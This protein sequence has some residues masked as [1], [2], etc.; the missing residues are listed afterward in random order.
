MG[1]GLSSRSQN[2]KGR[3]A[4]CCL[5]AQSCPTLCD[6]MDCS[7]LGS[8]VHGISQAR[9]L[10]WVAICFSRGSS[11]PRDRTW[12]S[13]ITG[14]FFFF[15]FFNH[16]ATREARRKAWWTFIKK[17]NQII[18]WTC[19]LNRRV[20]KTHR[21]PLIH[22]IF[23]IILETSTR[24]IIKGN[25]STQERWYVFL[26][27]NFYSTKYTIYLLVILYLIL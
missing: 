5:V 25:T 10:E 17:T 1:Q 22:H 3:R 9:I 16:W 11:P 8:S 27:E 23:R 6:P 13:C 14:Q 18:S 19:S 26:F 20:S 7:P 24:K 15:F 21:K 2:L 12:V 4:Y